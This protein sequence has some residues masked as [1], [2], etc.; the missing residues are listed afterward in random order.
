MSEKP[1][2]KIASAPRRFLWGVLGIAVLTLLFGF[3][4]AIATGHVTGPDCIQIPDNSSLDGPTENPKPISRPHYDCLRLERVS[5]P[6]ELQEG[7]SGRASMAEDQGML[8]IFSTATKQCFWMKDMHFPL[9]MIWLDQDKKVV[10]VHKNVQPESYPISFCPDKP[11]QYVIEIN[12]GVANKAY[13][14]EGSQ[15]QF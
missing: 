15:L 9:D 1:V 2:E 5:S 6:E 3:W 10:T 14:S 8:F 12:A 13:I 7:L 4:V 11:A